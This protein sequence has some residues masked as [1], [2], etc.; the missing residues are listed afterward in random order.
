MRAALRKQW[1]KNAHTQYLME[2]LDDGLYHWFEGTLFPSEKYHPQYHDL[3]LRQ[4]EIGWGQLLYGRFSQEWNRCQYRYLRENGYAVSNNTHG[5]KWLMG[6]IHTIWEHV[7]KEWD[8]R[9]KARH[10]EDPQTQASL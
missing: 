7:Q 5:S 4:E 6:F 9:N 10:G 2:I 8:T 3:I 1:G